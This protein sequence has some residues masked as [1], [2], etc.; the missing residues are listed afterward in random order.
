MKKVFFSLILFLF[1]FLFKTNIYAKEPAHVLIVNQVRGEECCSKGSLDKL[2]I[3][4]DAHISK[5]IP[6]YF[7]LRYDVLTDDIFVNYLK[8][9]GTKY[10][11]LIKFGLLIEMT[12]QL[13]KTVGVNHNITAENWFEAQNAFTIGYTKEDSIKIVDY[14]FSLFFEKF[15]YYPVVTSAWM[16]DTPTLNYIHD[17]YG[18]KIHQITREQYGT[19]SY[20]LYGGPPHYPYPAS[21]NWL[22]IPDYENDDPVLI[23]RQTITDP[24]FN[25]GDNTSTFTSQPNDYMKSKKTFDY[26]IS[27]LDQVIYQ[28]GSQTGFALLGLENS[29]EDKFQEEYIAQIELLGKRNSEGMIKFITVDEL[30]SYWKQN[31]ISI[32]YGKN[33]VNNLDWEAFWITTPFYRI[34]LIKKNDDILITDLRLYDKNYSDPYNNYEAKKSG[35]WIVPYLI[36][37]SFSY[38]DG[39]QKQSQIKNISNLPDAGYGLF[40]IKKDFEINPN[41]I[42]LPRILNKGDIKIKNTDD[43]IELS[44]LKSSKEKFTITFYDQ[45]IILNSLN[46]NEILYLSNDKNLSP[47]KFKKTPSGFNL[48]WLINEEIALGLT[49]TCTNKVC[50]I[51]FN[52]NPELL[53]KIRTEQYPFIFPEPINR[54]TDLKKSLFYPHNQYAVADRNPVRLIFSSRDKYDSPVIT[55]SNID[56]FTSTPVTKTSIMQNPAN[57]FIQYVDIYNDQP[58]KYSVSIKLNEDLEFKL[59]KPIYFAPNCKKKIKYCL[60]HPAETYWY[61]MSFI[62]DKLRK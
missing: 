31:K 42:V 60:T 5:K 53:P 28:S 27:L 10:P 16:I 24:L 9:V 48:N 54:Q 49:N 4:V 19:D 22:F 44:Y 32:Y 58:K 8:E 14:L 23:V 29:M 1:L 40:D 56:I 11:D 52:D 2:K 47:I 62:G 34:R 26:F 35:Y 18:V 57:Q 33:F 30:F 51:I 12:P 41:A 7:A 45:K 38:H 39:A 3:Q 46:N 55:T 21:K 13:I 61:L 36:N 37:G 20:T 17:T 43:K 15:G 25:Y 6:A 59:N 50:K